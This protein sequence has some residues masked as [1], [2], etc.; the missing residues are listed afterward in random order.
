VVIDEQGNELFDTLNRGYKRSLVEQDLDDEDHRYY[1]TAGMMDLQL[2][3]AAHELLEA[4]KDEVDPIVR[5]GVIGP[6]QKGLMP[7]CR[8]DECRLERARAAIAKAEGDS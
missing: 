2:A 8:C 3:A 4:L 6:C 7:R 1:D 5:S